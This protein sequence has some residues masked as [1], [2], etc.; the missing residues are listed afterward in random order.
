MEDLIRYYTE[1]YDYV[2]FDL[3]HTREI[4]ER[5]KDYNLSFAEAM[6]ARRRL[7]TYYE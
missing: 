3:K 1:T 4:I 7:I 2:H 6:K 5:A